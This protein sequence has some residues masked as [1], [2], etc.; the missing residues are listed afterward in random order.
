[1]TTASPTTRPAGYGVSQIALHWIIA[2]LVFFQLV[3]GESMGKIGWMTRRG[4]TPSATDYLMANLHIYAGVAILV[5]AL[6]RLYVR[7]KQGVPAAPA[8]GNPMLKKIAAG[9]HHLFYLLLIVVPVTGLVAEY[10]YRPAGEIHEL[11]KPV[12]IVLIAVHAAA[13]LYHQFVVKDGV[14]MRML[15]PG[16]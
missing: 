12:F 3:F 6:I 11:A 2:A 1:M 8:G 9:M 4:E 7:I 14:L 13:A 5:L 16:A 15:K 10:L